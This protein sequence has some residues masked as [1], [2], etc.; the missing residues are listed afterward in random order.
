M[1]KVMTV[2]SVQA[3]F[4]NI[5]NDVTRFNEPVT[6]VSDDNQAVVIVNIDE[7]NII[8]K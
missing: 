1:L 4:N 5:F 3:D 8:W 6:V 2:K 7:W